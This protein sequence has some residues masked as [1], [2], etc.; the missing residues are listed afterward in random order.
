MAGCASIVASLKK[1]LTIQTPSYDS[2]GQGGFTETWLDGDTVWASI[3]PA[4]AYERYQ[5][6][7]MQVPIT[8][9]IVMR[10]NPS[11]AATSRLKFG[12]RI[13]GVKEVINE[14]EGDRFLFIRAIELDVA[15][16]A[17]IVTA[18]QLDF[19]IAANSGLL[20]VV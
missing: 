8:H 9:K 15:E 20:G 14:H 11:V 17:P 5:A 10:Y 13:F 7:Q 19:S 1:R 4:K 3:E 12:S 16:F 6:M 2:D 18:S